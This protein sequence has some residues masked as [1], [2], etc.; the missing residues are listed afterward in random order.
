[1]T[2]EA[3]QDME[4]TVFKGYQVLT[5]ILDIQ[6]WWCIDLLGGFGTH[7]LSLVLIRSIQEAKYVSIKDE[8]DRS[9]VN[10]SFDHLVT[11]GDNAS[12]A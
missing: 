1:M 7:F 6:Q 10:Q 12:S 2:T 11:K 3:W 8:S 5:L 4:C 9:H